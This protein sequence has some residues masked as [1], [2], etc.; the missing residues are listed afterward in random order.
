MTTLTVTS[1]GQVT[2]RRDILQHLGVAAGDRIDVD[3]L[4][5]AQ[6]GLRAAR[7]RGSITDLRGVLKNKTN[8]RQL[9]IDDIGEAIA[10]AGANAGDGRT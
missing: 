10:K 4:P 5:D 8:G 7:R 1:R 3:L 2:L 9:S 6:A